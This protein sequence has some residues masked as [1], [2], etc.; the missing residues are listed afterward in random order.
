MAEHGDTPTIWM[1]WKG[2]DACFDFWCACTDED[3]EGDFGHADLRFAYAIE[4]ARCGRKYD[5]PQTLELLP[6]SGKYEPVIVNGF[7]DDLG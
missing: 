3:P 5:M 4:C 6:F 1:Q 7:G 2:T